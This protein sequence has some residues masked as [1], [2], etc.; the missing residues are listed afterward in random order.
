MRR[1]FGRDLSA[2]GVALIVVGLI[3]ALMIPP[4]SVS[5]VSS[6]VKKSFTTEDTEEHRAK[7]KTAP[8]NQEGWNG[9]LMAVSPFDGANRIRFKGSLTHCQLAIADCRLI[10]LGVR[11][12]L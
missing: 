8:P 9:Q 3:A 1:E 7:T 12:A 10:P 5:S 2:S 11:C 4:F 6:V